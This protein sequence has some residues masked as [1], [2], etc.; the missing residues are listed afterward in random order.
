MARAPEWAERT[1]SHSAWAPLLVL[2]PAVV[3][4]SDNE[5]GAFMDEIG[6]FKDAPLIGPNDAKTQ[7]DLIPRDAEPPVRRIRRQLCGLPRQHQSSRAD[8]RSGRDAGEQRISRVPYAF[9]QD[10]ASTWEQYE[11]V[12]SG[13]FV[14]AVSGCVAAETYGREYVVERLTRGPGVSGGRAA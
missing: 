13:A 4:L 7:L 6:S 12:G 10:V 3:V 2:L 8:V 1:S 5:Y 9:V 11:R 14:R